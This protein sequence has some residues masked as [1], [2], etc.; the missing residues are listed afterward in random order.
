MKKAITLIVLCVFTGLN[1]QGQIIKM[2][3]KHIS[4][5]IGQMEW[6]DWE[7]YETLA[8]INEDKNQFIFYVEP[9]DVYEIISHNPSSKALISLNVLDKEGEE[10]IIDLTEGLDNGLPQMYIRYPDAV[11]A[12]TFEMIE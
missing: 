2:R 6:S 4:Q 12:I 1:V 7:K 5:K 10:C 8:V 9:K 3:T 11:M